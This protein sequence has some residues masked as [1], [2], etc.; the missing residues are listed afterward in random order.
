MINCKPLAS[1]PQAQRAL[2]DHHCFSDLLFMPTGVHINVS[3][4]SGSHNF[5]HWLYGGTIRLTINVNIYHECNVNCILILCVHYICHLSLCTCCEVIKPSSG[6]WRSVYTDVH[7]AWFW[8][9]MQ[10]AIPKASVFTQ[11]LWTA[12]LCSE[13]R[14]ALLLSF[15]A[16]SYPR[17]E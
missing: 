12:L 9:F 6:L 15:T 13:K 10:T 1:V 4:C 2:H 16:G 5:S 17:Q 11:S 3:L 14:T 7:K 8:N